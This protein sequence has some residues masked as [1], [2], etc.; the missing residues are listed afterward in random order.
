[1]VKFKL[2][3]FGFQQTAATNTCLQIFQLADQLS[4]VRQEF[5]GGVP[6]QR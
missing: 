2:R 5:G 4:V 1:M 6:G 3:L